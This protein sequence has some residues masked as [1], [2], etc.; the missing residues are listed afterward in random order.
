M[1]RQVFHLDPFQLGA[2]KEYT[3]DVFVRFVFSDAGDGFSCWARLD[4]YDRLSIMM[5]S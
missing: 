5:I 4:S 3:F 2:V 1:P